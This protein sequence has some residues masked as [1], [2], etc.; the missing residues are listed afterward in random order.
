MRDMKD[1]WLPED[2]PKDASNLGG[3][4]MHFNVGSVENPSLVKHYSDVFSLIWNFLFWTII[5]LSCIGIFVALLA[6][7]ASILP[8]VL[9]VVGVCIIYVLMPNNN[10]R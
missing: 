7:V 10:P 6:F 4:P 2:N 5:I 1:W 9:W 3:I 8:I